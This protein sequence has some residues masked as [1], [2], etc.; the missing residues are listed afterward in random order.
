MNHLLFALLNEE[1]LVDTK[2]KL[3]YI[4][5]ISGEPVHI[6]G[7]QIADLSQFTSVQLKEIVQE[8]ENL[9]SYA[10]SYLPAP[11][12][13]APNR[14]DFY[15]FN[16][17]RTDENYDDTY[18]EQRKQYTSFLEQYKKEHDISSL[19]TEEEFIKAIMKQEN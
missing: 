13:L 1:S 2:E 10:L 9:T 12:T 16:D 19:I 15:A 11:G 8:E 6:Y 5:D 3:L 17:I 14:M 18:E 7:F 4:P